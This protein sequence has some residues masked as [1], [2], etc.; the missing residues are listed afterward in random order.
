MVRHKL[1]FVS[2]IMV[3]HKLQFVNYIMVRTSWISMR[4]WWYLRCTRTTHLVGFDSASSLVQHP[5]S[6]HVAPLGH[7][8]L[9]PSLTSLCSCS[10]ILCR[11]NKYKS[12]N[13]WFDPTEAQN[14]D[15]LHANHYT[16][17]VVI[18][19]FDWCRIM[20]TL[21]MQQAIFKLILVFLCKQMLFERKYIFYVLTYSIHTMFW[22]R[23]LCFSY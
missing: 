8:I 19:Y 12:C 22:N 21:S 9:I 23:V 3:R 11:S 20:N 16:T 1:Q 6:R 17:D 15:Q 7:I 13:F 5:V 10:I 14:Q 2:Y 18:H 4:W